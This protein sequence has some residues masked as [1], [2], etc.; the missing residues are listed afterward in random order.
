MAKTSNVEI[1]WYSDAEQHDYAF[2]E[3]CLSSMYSS[4]RVSTALANLQ[5]A[6]VTQFKAKDIFQAAQPAK[7]N[8]GKTHSE[9]YRRK[10]KAG[11]AMSPLLLVRNGMLGKLVV[12]SGYRHLC[13][14]Y[15]MDQNALVPCKIA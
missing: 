11:E 6:T 8:A 1:K 14:V 15:E 5:T 3:S 7:L 10:I 13:A 2:A 4:D 12:A 9:I